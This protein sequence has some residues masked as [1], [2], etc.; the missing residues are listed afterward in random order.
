ML[1]IPLIY[2]C[3]VL[4]TYEQLTIRI[5]AFTRELP[6]TRWLVRLLV[7]TRCNL[8]LR[9][10]VLWS[11]RLPGIDM[12]STKALPTPFIFLPEAGAVP[13]PT[14]F[15]YLDW[16]SRPTSHMRL[17]TGPDGDGLSLYGS[18]EET[19]LFPLYGCKVDSECYH[20]EHDRLYGVS[21]FLDGKDAFDQ[22][23]YE[24]SATY[25]PPAFVSGDG[26]LYKYKWKWP[27]ERAELMLSYEAQH[28]RV[29]VYASR[30]LKN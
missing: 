29:S 14:D 3:A 17:L 13:P 6:E 18:T 23:R 30:E 2:F 19:P 20:Y 8:N 24:W 16:G 15:R 5:D 25:G 7:L 27:D 28:D 10:L 11:R 4:A 9:R 26:H 12:G 21:V 1:F 22:G